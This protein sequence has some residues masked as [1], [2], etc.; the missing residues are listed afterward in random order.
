MK[1][2][3]WPRFKQ[4]FN[5]NFMDFLLI[6]AAEDEFINRHKHKSSMIAEQRRYGKDNKEK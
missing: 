4:A 1:K 5:R 2:A 3:W 6:F